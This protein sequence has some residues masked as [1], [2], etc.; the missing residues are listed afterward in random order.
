MHSY[1]VQVAY[2]PEGLAALLRKP[3]DRIKKVAPAVES[4]G[5]KIL[6][7]GYSL[8]DYDIAVIVNLPNNEAVAALSMAFSAG[9]AI[10]AVKTTPL[11]SGTEAVRA[12]KKASQT[13]YKPAK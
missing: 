7:G 2:S 8:G 4:L 5:G 1:L 3:Q 6:A 10:R 11:L 9:G 13:G 12:M